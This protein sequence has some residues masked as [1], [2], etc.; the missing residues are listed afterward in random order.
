MLSLDEELKLAERK[1]AEVRD[2]FSNGWKNIT[3]EE[4]LRSKLATAYELETVTCHGR[5]F[6]FEY[7]NTIGSALVTDSG[8]RLNN[9]ITLFVDGVLSSYWIDNEGKAQVVTN[10]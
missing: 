5:S 3:T 1:Y 4:E 7:G 8:L 10:N 2:Y 6:N 9:I